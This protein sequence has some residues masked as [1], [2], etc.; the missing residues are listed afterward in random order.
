MSE[1]LLCPFCGN[2]PKVTHFPTGKSIVECCGA[3]NPMSIDRWNTRNKPSPEV[4][5]EGWT[6]KPC[7]KCNGTGENNSDD[8]PNCQYCGGTGDE[9][10][11]PEARVDEVEELANLC[12][13]QWSGWMGYLFSLC[14]I[15]NNRKPV[16]SR[17]NYE[18]WALQMVTDYENLSEEEKESDRI[19]ARKILALGYRRGKEKG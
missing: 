14:H 6:G 15:S 4:K 10:V 19:E 5:K 9:Y 8:T 7:S 3:V 16:I 13:E 11:F 17:E 2:E 12:H 1:L 18:R